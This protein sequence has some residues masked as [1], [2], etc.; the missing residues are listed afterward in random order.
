[1]AGDSGEQK[2]KLMGSSNAWKRKCLDDL[3]LLCEE[4]EVQKTQVALLRLRLSQGGGLAPVADCLSVIA[5]E[6][7]DTAWKTNRALAAAKLMTKGVGT[8][9]LGEVMPEGC[10][11]DVGTWH[12]DRSPIRNT[13]L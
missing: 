9:A 2:A 5:A 10:C 8:S 13:I 4:S 3:N 11:V 12:F 6:P 1:M 7:Q